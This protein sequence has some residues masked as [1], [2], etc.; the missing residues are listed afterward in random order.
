MSG[1]PVLPIPRRSATHQRR[2]SPVEHQTPLPLTSR[3]DESALPDRS[4]WPNG[5]VRLIATFSASSCCINPRARVSAPPG[6]IPCHR[7][8]L[9]ASPNASFR[10][11]PE[12]TD[13]VLRCENRR[14]RREGPIGELQPVRSW[15]H[16][17][18][19]HRDPSCCRRE[20]RR[21]L[22]CAMLPQHSDAARGARIGRPRTTAP[23]PLDRI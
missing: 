8:L 1:T 2:A 23:S 11:P 5:A 14:A 19:R 13:R 18:P 21:S 22:L 7:W 9:L 6:P 15:K 10:A 4:P 3:P 16:W 17:V 12:T 20:A